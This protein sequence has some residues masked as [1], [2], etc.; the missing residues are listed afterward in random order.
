MDDLRDLRGH[1]EVSTPA[2]AASRAAS[3]ISPCSQPARLSSRPAKA[4]VVVT[5]LHT[6]TTNDRDA[7]NCFD[8]SLDV[9]SLHVDAG[10]R[11]CVSRGEIIGILGGAAFRW[12]MTGPPTRAER[13]RDGGDW[14]SSETTEDTVLLGEHADRCELH[15]SADARGARGTRFR[16]MSRR[17]L[18]AP[19]RSRPTVPR[20]VSVDTSYLVLGEG[21]SETLRVYRVQ[22][23][24]VVSAFVEIEDV[25]YKFLYRVQRGNSSRVAY[26]GKGNAV[27]ELDATGQRR[28]GELHES[29]SLRWDAKT[30][31]WGACHW[32]CRP[33]PS[34]H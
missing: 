23:G 32:K 24:K 14:S 16:S 25:R 3:R 19:S 18:S 7:R 31:G 11:A 15:L 9:P 27:L 22:P 30:G 34:A 6:G 21:D 13:F 2:V 5:N 8:P 20:S 33:L 4:L 26:I 12:S 1:A 10:A 28:I 29:E 17:R